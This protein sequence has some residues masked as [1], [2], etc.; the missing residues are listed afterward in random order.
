M[1]LTIMQIL[2]YFKLIVYVH[3]LCNRVLKELH[4]ITTRKAYFSR[5]IFFTTHLLS[6]TAGEAGKPTIIAT[7]FPES[8]NMPRPRL[9]QVQTLEYRYIDQARLMDLLSRLFPPQTYA[10]QVRITKAMELRIFT[11]Q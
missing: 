2:G 11:D 8:K 1:M 10:A 3:I 7:N 6:P 9:A 4:A 5:C